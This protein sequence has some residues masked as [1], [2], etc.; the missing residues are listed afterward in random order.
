[1]ENRFSQVTARHH[2]VKG[3]GELGPTDARYTRK[4]ADDREVC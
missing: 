1:M 2:V 4:F 3:T